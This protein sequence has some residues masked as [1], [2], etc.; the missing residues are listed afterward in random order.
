MKLKQSDLYYCILISSHL[1]IS[2]SN[3]SVD[4]SV[5]PGSFA[6]PSQPVQPT[7]SMPT[8]FRSKTRKATNPRKTFQRPHHLFCQTDVSLKWI[9]LI[10][11]LNDHVFVN[12][13]SVRSGFKD[14]A[15]TDNFFGK[16]RRKLPLIQMT[17]FLNLRNGYGRKLTRKFLFKVYPFPKKDSPGGPKCRQINLDVS[18]KKLCVS[19]R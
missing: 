19:K 18:L 15:I 9:N 3:R 1:P 2:A 8:L 10:F 4:S 11:L 13:W 5:M 6:C 16:L 12:V 17:I 7:N 14:C